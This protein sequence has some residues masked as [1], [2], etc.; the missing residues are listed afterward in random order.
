M[1]EIEGEREGKESDAERREI[2]S[3]S[4][5]FS[6]AGIEDCTRDPGNREQE[7]ERTAI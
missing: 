3:L 5:S 7:R 2:V 1:T 6:E 4:L